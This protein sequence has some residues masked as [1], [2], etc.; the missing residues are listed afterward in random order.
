L[1]P[2]LL[3]C[4]D[5]AELLD[6]YIDDDDDRRFENTVIAAELGWDDVSAHE[7]GV[8]VSRRITAAERPCVE[9]FLTRARA[10]DALGTFARLLRVASFARDE[11]ETRVLH[12][13]DAFVP[14]NKS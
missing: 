14:G 2:A 13:L 12:Q 1:L 5:I 3:R 6:G 4:G 8:D 10:G 7:L 11:R 9:Q